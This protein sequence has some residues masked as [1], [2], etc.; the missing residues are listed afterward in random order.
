M[1]T[2]PNHLIYIGSPIPFDTDHFLSQ[3][4]ELMR[5]S[6]AEEGDIRKLVT[7]IVNTYHPSGEEG[8]QT[9]KQARRHM[10]EAAAR[11]IG[12]RSPFK[13]DWKSANIN[14]MSPRIK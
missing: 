8:P 7:K 13:A 2:T 14:T 3:L 10:N 4:K 9:S 6:Y 12:R 11:H 5:A 1:K